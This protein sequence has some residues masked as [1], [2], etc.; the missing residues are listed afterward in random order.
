GTQP[1]AVTGRL[2]GLAV[3]P[4]L[5]A[6]KSST[7]MR[8]DRRCVSVVDASIAL[9]RDRCCEPIAH[10][11]IGL[12]WWISWYIASPPAQLWTRTTLEGSPADRIN[13]P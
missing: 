5:E 10:R 8:S 13:P 4:L 11:A 6:R 2:A 3:R 7:S 9:R 12:R 1:R